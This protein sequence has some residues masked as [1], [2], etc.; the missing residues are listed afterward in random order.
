[1]NETGQWLLSLSYIIVPILTAITGGTY[2][3]VEELVRDRKKLR[4][5]PGLAAIIVGGISMLIT[6]VILANIFF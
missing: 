5:L 4:A 2:Y 6:F 3:V 1:M